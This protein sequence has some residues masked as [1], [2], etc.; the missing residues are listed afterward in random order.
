[1][2]HP[3]FGGGR[4]GWR[5]VFRMTIRNWFY[6]KYYKIRSVWMSWS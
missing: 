2:S 6:E 4:I 3:L 1:M 5:D